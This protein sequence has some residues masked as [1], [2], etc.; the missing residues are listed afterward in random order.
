LLPG[1]GGTTINSL[2]F[3][4]RRNRLATVPRAA[5]NAFSTLSRDN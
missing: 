2:R 5:G 3:L 4:W 1:R